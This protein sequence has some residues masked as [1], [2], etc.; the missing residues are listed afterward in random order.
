[1]SLR[2]LKRYQSSTKIYSVFCED[3]KTVFII[4]IRAVIPT[5]W[6]DILLSDG[7][8]MQ[9]YKNAGHKNRSEPIPHPWSIAGEKLIPTEQRKA[10]VAYFYYYYLVYEIEN[11]KQTMDVLKFIR[12]AM[13]A[14]L[15]RRYIK[16]SLYK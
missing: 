1:M 12:A 2:D 9:H 10:M 8:V 16:P 6:S 3:Y 7:L 14:A 15:T 11:V 4:A 5:I 13:A